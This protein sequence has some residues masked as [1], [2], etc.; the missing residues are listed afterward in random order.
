[1]PTGRLVFVEGQ[2]DK[3]VLVSLVGTQVTVAGERYIGIM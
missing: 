3:E 1:M 2:V